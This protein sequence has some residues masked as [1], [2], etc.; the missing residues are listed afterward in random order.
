M[1][2]SASSPVADNRHTLAHRTPA[3]QLRQTDLN[4]PG[5]ALSSVPDNAIKRI[6]AGVKACRWS[7]RQ[8]RSGDW[9]SPSCK[10]SVERKK[11]ERIP[12][13]RL[14][15][16]TYEFG[17]FLTTTEDQSQSREGQADKFRMSR[18][19][20]SSPDASKRQLLIRFPAKATPPS[21][22]HHLHNNR[23]S[24]V[25]GPGGSKPSS[26]QISYGHLAMEVRKRLPSG[27]RLNPA[28]WL[29]D[30]GRSSGASILSAPVLTA[31]A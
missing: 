21:K 17:R 18:R 16:F 9:P 4:Y 23:S 7:H 28:I 20:D 12:A 14:Q 1:R 11:N 22:L 29:T 15:A 26:I 8:V 25:F 6:T 30:G 10:D 2:L 13:R 5:S 31:I 27:C 19:P 3:R 24:H